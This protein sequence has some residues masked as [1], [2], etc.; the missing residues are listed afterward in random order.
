MQQLGALVDRT[1]VDGPVEKDLALPSPKR[2]RAG[3][4]KP[5]IV[6]IQGPLGYGK[7][8]LFRDHGGSL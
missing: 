2:L 4:A 7:G 5:L 6:L 1:E 8:L 3:R